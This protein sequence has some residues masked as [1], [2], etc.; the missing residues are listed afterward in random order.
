[1]HCLPNQE[2]GNEYNPYLHCKAGIIDPSLRRDDFGGFEGGR[3]RLSI[4]SPNCHSR[5]GGNL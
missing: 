4:K 1:M 3:E 5:G 2:V